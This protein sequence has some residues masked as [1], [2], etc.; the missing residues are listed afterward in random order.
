MAT[1]QVIHVTKSCSS[2]QSGTNLMSQIPASKQSVMA[3]KAIEL[4][5]LRYFHIQ[6]FD[7]VEINLWETEKKN[8]CR[9]LLPSLEQVV[10]ACADTPG[11][12]T[13]CLKQIWYNPKFQI[14]LKGL[15]PILRSLIAH[16][17]TAMVHATSGFIKVAVEEMSHALWEM[18]VLISYAN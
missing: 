9:L 11:A 2:E 3:V 4:T 13:K 15:Y 18:M 14:S 8:S 12:L 6:H 10:E 16:S 17:W 1:L 5:H 7:G